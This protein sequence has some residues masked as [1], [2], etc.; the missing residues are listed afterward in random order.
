MKDVKVSRVG[1]IQLEATCGGPLCPDMIDRTTICIAKKYLL[2][3]N[4][5]KVGSDACAGKSRAGSHSA[6]LCCVSR[7]AGCTW[8]AADSS[9]W[10]LQEKV[11]YNR[12]ACYS[13]HLLIKNSYLWINLQEDK[14]ATLRKPLLITLL[15]GGTSGF[16]WHTL[17]T[18]KHRGNKPRIC[19]HGLQF[20]SIPDH[21][22]WWV[23][24]LYTQ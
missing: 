12:R 4:H 9:L 1:V 8:H 7:G 5:R 3:I 16:T 14:N 24:L 10:H 20:K 13:S 11:N 21:Y 18:G 22:F 19:F 23:P 15:A 17:L 6:F 2:S